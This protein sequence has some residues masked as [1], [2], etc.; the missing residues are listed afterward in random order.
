VPILLDGAQRG[1]RFVALVLVGKRQGGDEL[2]AGAAGLVAGPV[3]VGAEGG[4]GK[5][6]EHCDANEDAPEAAPYEP[7]LIGTKFLVDFTDEAIVVECHSRLR[8]GPN[9]IFSKRDHAS[10]MQRVKG[11][12]T[13]FCRR[14]KGELPKSCHR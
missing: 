8:P 4:G 13:P 12:S 9:S 6:D 14:C 10:W 11:P 3:A 2:V 7:Q 1:K 5:D